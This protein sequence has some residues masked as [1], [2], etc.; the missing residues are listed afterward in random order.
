M[1]KSHAVSVKSPRRRITQKNHILLSCHRSAMGKQLNLYHHH[2]IQILLFF[3]LI[4]D[5]SETFTAIN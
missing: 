2:H 5:F 1:A 4:S 3:F